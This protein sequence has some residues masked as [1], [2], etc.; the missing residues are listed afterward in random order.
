LC[1]ITRGCITSPKGWQSR[2]III[3]ARTA[4]TLE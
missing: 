4:T 1:R 2:R 3:K